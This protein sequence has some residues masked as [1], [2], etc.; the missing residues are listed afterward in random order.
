MEIISDL[1]S[2]NLSYRL[3]CFRR[4]TSFRID[5]LGYVRTYVQLS[6]GVFSALDNNKILILI[7]FLSVNNRNKFPSEI[8]YEKLRIT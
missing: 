4:C 7:F 2:Y 5:I 6:R 8:I 1:K 3:D